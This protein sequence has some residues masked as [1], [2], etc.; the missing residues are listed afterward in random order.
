L[1]PYKY[2]SI[3][4]IDLRLIFGALSDMAAIIQEFYKFN[5]KFKKNIDNH[6]KWHVT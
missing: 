5:L 4:A 2:G 1:V 3:N 6:E